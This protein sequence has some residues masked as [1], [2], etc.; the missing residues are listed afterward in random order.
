M[1]DDS[2]KLIYYPPDRDIYFDSS[3]NHKPYIYNGKAWVSL[4][5][6][7]NK[8]ESNNELLI[9]ELEKIFIMMTESLM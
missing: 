8:P 2:C 9:N 4:Y 1:E 5:D 6:E 7:C 3:D